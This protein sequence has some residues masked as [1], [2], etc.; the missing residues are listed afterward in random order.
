MPGEVSLTCTL[1][2]NYMPVTNTE[3][4][5]Y[6]LLEAVPT[7][8]VANVRM[9]LNFALALDH[10]GSMAGDKLQKVKEAVRL[11]VDQMSPQDIIAVV[12][13]D[14]KARVIVSS[15][16]VSNREQIKRH[17]D[18]IR[19]GGGTEMSK[20]MKL[21]LDEAQR[22][23]APDRVNRIL[24][25]TDGETWGDEAQ[26]RTLA[27]QAKAV[28]VSIEPFGVGEE[29]N[30]NLLN[31]IAV[32]SGSSAGFARYI[33]TPAEI[34]TEFQGLLKSMQA[35]GAQNAVLTLRLVLGVKPRAVFRVLP[36]IANLG[37]RYIND[38]DVSM[39]LGDLEKGQ[40]QTILVEMLVPPRQAGAFRI[41]QAEVSYD[42]PALGI[43]GEKVKTD[44]VLN[45]TADPNLAAQA[46]P[47]IMNIVE[48]VTAFKLQ[49][50]AL[51][52]AE[53]GNV[54]GATQKLRAAATRLLDMGEKELATRVLQ[55]AD[56]LQQQGQMSAGG[57][58][59][60]ER[61]TRKLTQKLDLDS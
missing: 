42:I 10:S 52:D 50:R 56:L 21:A 2:K 57:A 7:Q 59:E 41:A 29:W 26:C 33:A 12:E 40:G 47:R 13:F 18:G 9:P 5:A 23:R 34:V 14:D 3:Q 4:L 27:D 22:Y 17:V 43:V 51:Q 15:Q 35:V 20:G 36:A 19:D 61:Q 58:K 53:A 46:D 44:I 39:E 16:P 32:R 55:E 48:K 28:G 37:T 24:L 60:I 54:A 30:Q 45:F 38:R 31:D 6:L 49:T 11:V 25:L 1:G 8:A